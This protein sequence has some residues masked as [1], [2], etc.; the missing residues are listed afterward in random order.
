ME[1][2]YPGYRY[3]SPSHWLWG[4]GERI[5]VHFGDPRATITPDDWI[6]VNPDEESNEAL[7]RLEKEFPI[8]V[9]KVRYYLGEVHAGNAI[10][11]KHHTT[12]MELSRAV[13]ELAEVAGEGVKTKPNTT[14]LRAKAITSFSRKRKC[15]VFTENLRV[16]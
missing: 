13:L 8:P 3:G 14:R 11:F 4:W 1:A 5:R 15:A 10:P 9:S 12:L 7:D 6:V 2:E 16:G